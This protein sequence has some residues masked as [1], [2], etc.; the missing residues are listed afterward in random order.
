MLNNQ[1]VNSS[2]IP[3][4]R[5]VEV[6]SAGLFLARYRMNHGRSTGASPKVLVEAH[7]AFHHWQQRATK[8][9]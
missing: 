9:Y 7:G 2:A 5:A 3:Y 4:R 8:T 6:R 1:R